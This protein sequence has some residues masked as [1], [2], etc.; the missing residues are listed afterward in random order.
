MSVARY[1]LY[2]TAISPFVRK[3][4]VI[5]ALK[6]VAYDF[7]PV[8]VFQPPDWFLAIS[9][10]KRVPV[11]RDRS[12]GDATLADSSAIAVYL[13]AEHPQPR[14]IPDD[15]WAAGQVA[16]L[17]E[18]ADTEFAFRLGMGVFRAR[19]L[20]PKIGKPVD[21][22]LARKTLDEIAPRYFDF[23]EKT[24]DGR[25]FLVGD[26]LTLAD[27]AVATHLVNF[28]YGGERVDAARWPGFAAFGG[29]MLALPS[30]ADLMRE[31][32]VALP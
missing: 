20:N 3:I 30:F 2:G 29:R 5:L 26:A 31:E 7:E 16:W 18:Y 8:N 11:L 15:A 22:A 17:E 25:E 9:P 1:V 13:D 32:G 10:L 24:L 6:G 28:A 19:Y 27:I 23:F 14:F 4:R 21:E 12:R